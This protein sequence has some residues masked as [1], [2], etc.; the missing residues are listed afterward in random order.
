MIPRQQ[1][2][3][4]IL[5]QI[6]QCMKNQPAEDALRKPF[7]CRIDRRNPAKVNRLVFVVLDHFKFGMLHADALTAQT[8]LA[9]DDQPLPGR[10]HFLDVMQIKPAQ[11]E[12]LAERI[13]VAFLKSRLED[14]FEATE[15]SQR[16][17]RRLHRRCRAACRFPREGSRQIRVDPRGASDNAS[18]NLQSWRCPTD[19]AARSGRE[20][21]TRIPPVPGRAASIDRA[22]CAQR[23]DM[24]LETLFSEVFVRLQTKR[25]VPWR[26]RQRFA[27]TIKV[28]RARVKILLPQT[29]QRGVFPSP[30]AAPP[31]A[32]RR[33][34][35]RWA[36]RLPLPNGAR[37]SCQSSR[38]DFRSRSTNS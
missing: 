31:S 24:K 25:D 7:R 29:E 6:F 33:G 15:A 38:S 8:R 1:G 10:D 11:D 17:L 37:A 35:R 32:P 30:P 19:A 18:A 3:H 5:G 27:R 16:S 21:P 26:R 13:R 23:L 14:F 9:E 4:F 34:Q 36:A 12:R 22:G 28:N 20:A 2:F